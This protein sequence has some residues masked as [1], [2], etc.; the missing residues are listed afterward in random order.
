[1]SGG[2]PEP[3]HRPLSPGEGGGR[4]AGGAGTEAWHPEGHDPSRG[5]CVMDG[6]ENVLRAIRFQSPERIP[7]AFWR[8]GPNDLESLEF[9][10]LTDRIDSTHERDEFGCVW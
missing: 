4:P 2:P 1:R 5:R 9:A 8:W 6:R 7:C 3:D 10:P